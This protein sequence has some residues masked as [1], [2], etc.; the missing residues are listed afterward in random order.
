[1]NLQT[2]ISPELWTAVRR[3]Y[4]SQAWS[5]AILDGI[6]HLSDVIRAR[7][8]LH[9]DGTALAGQAFG[10]KS[11]KL[12]LNKLQT[13]TDKSIQA[14]VEQLLRGIYQAIRNPRSH[15]R[16]EDRQAD[17][18]AL[19]VFVNYVLGLIGHAKTSFSLEETV[20]RVLDEDFVPNMRYAELLVEEIPA[21]QRLQVGL[22]T[23]GLRAQAN[24]ERLGFFFQTL[25][26]KLSTEDRAEYFAALSRELRDSSG[27]DSL[28]MVLQILRPE[29]WPELSEVARLRSEHRLLKNFRGGLADI[30]SGECLSGGLATLAIPF[31]P[32]FTLKKEFMEA[33]TDGLSASRPEALAYALSFALDHL[34]SLADKPPGRLQAVIANRIKEGNASVYLSVKFDLIWKKDTWNKRVNEAMAAYDAMQEQQ[35]DAPPPQ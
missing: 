30:E 19:L 21:R 3:S 5:N 24:P 26:E 31:W 29:Q 16:V 23:L 7:T 6:H 27:E 15:G 25:L 12:S 34:S 1:M 14:G 17:A 33:A 2:Q 4:E 18:D 8:D 13:E 28:R 35:Q 9:S 22:E 32:H 11:P 20:A 10:G